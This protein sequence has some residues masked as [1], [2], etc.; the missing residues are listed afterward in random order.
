MMKRRLVVTFLAIGLLVTMVLIASLLFPQ[1]FSGGKIDSGEGNKAISFS[2]AAIQL[3]GIAIIALIIIFY[4]LIPWR[5][6][7]VFRGFSNASTLPE[8]DKRTIDINILAQEELV[9]QFKYLYHSLVKYVNIE[10]DDVGGFDA[11]TLIEKSPFMPQSQQKDEHFLNLAKFLPPR[12]AE[13]I[14]KELKKLLRTFQN[15]EE[16]GDLLRVIGESAPKEISPIMKLIDIIIPP[17]L[18]EATGH[19]QWHSKTLE[20]HHVGI[21]LEFTGSFTGSDETMPRTIWWRHTD[22]TADPDSDQKPDMLAPQRR[23]EHLLG[24]PTD[25]NPNQKPDMLD[26]TDRYIDLLAPAMCWLALTLWVYHS[27]SR[28]WFM[29][30]RRHLRAELHY[31]LGALYYAYSQ[32]KYSLYEDFFWELAVEHFNQATKLDPDW[33]VP[34]LY[35]ATIYNRKVQ[36]MPESEPY[37]KELSKRALERYEKAIQ[38]T[39][40]VRRRLQSQKFASSKINAVS[41]VRRKLLVAKTIAELSFYDKDHITAMQAKFVHRL[42]LLDDDNFNLSRADGAYLYDLACLYMFSFTKALS[43]P[44]AGKKAKYLLICSLARSP[45]LWKIAEEEPLFSRIRCFLEKGKIKLEAVRDKT[46]R[47]AKLKGQSFKDKIDEVVNQ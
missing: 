30:H 23:L 1:I 36:D 29:S 12:E 21:T 40:K 6:K 5:I 38:Y 32:E 43:F 4:I 11:D 28:H 41:L 2:L 24:W 13:E 34:H 39:K 37:K 3:G 25:P 14:I 8:L 16:Y 20:P 22:G 15:R 44:E 35:V 26:V 19:L 31:L 33:C 45:E 9:K 10:G 17:R 47:L 42:K 27:M 7:C 46:P 18:V